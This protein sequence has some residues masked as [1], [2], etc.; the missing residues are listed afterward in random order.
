MLRGTSWFF[1]IFLWLLY[2]PCHV[3][4]VRKLNTWLNCLYETS[5]IAPSNLA[6]NLVKTKGC[7]PQGKYLAKTFETLI[8]TIYMLLCAAE[9]HHPT[10]YPFTSEPDVRM[11]SFLSHC[12]I[13][14][15]DEWMQLDTVHCFSVWYLPVLSVYR[16]TPTLECHMTITI[17]C[18]IR[19][20]YQCDMD[21]ESDANIIII[22]CWVFIKTLAEVLSSF[23]RLMNAWDDHL[24]IYLETKY[25]IG[26]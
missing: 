8:K 18:V 20:A 5:K 21:H 3:E 9:Q 6:S 19:V 17:F 2:H 13:S 4:D 1:C 11:S 16:R 10:I 15:D 26:R 14:A 23:I 22:R 24:F 12:R 7:Q 25:F